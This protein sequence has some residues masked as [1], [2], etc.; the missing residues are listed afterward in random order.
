MFLKIIPVMSLCQLL[1]GFLWLAQD[2]DAL[3]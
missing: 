3:A 1:M 2:Y